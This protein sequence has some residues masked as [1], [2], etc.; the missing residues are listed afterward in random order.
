MEEPEAEEE[1]RQIRAVTRML[2][3]DL[4][5][6]VAMYTA[7]TSTERR[8]KLR[9]DFADGRVQCLVAIRCL[10]EGVDIPETKHAF[11][12]ASTS[13]PRQFIQRR[14]RL[15]RRSP[16]KEM[17]EIHDFVVAPPT[18]H[19]DAGSEHFATTRRLF[20]RELQR[21]AEFAKLATN[22]PEGHEPP[23]RH[24]G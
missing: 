3:N 16:G 5:M 14:G 12:L 20:G 2:G 10:D 24:P 4:L 6:R 9:D 21:V 19:R 15:L 23:I 1:M 17:A 18:K 7:E 22:G 11:I 13:N 8:R